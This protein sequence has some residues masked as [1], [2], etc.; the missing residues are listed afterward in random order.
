MH[1]GRS[2]PWYHNLPLLS[3][4]I[5]RGK[6]HCC[7]QPISPRY[8]AGEA[9]MALGYAWVA[10]RYGA[11]DPG[12]AVLLLGVLPCLMLAGWVDAQHGYIPDRASM[13]G[14]AWVL[15]GSAAWAPQ[16]VQAPFYAGLAGWETALGPSLS[17]FWLVLHNGLLASAGLLWFGFVMGAVLRKEAMGLGDVKLMGLLGCCYGALGAV[18]IVFLASWMACLFWLGRL[19][20]ARLQAPSLHTP[21]LPQATAAHGPVQPFSLPAASIPFGPWLCA[22]ALGYTVAG[23]SGVFFACFV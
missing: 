4:C 17:A 13:G 20:W 14:M 10:W 21:P 5:L 3:W 8:L 6:S 12:L 16:L 7:Q 11:A 1:C 23:S 18:L 2:L 22:A 15:L 9:L 19:G